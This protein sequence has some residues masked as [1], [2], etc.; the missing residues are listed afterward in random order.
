MGKN[1]KNMHLISEVAQYLH[2]SRSFILI[3]SYIENSSVLLCAVYIAHTNGS[4]IRQQISADTVSHQFSFWISEPCRNDPQIKK[5]S[6]VWTLS[7]LLQFSLLHETLYLSVMC[8]VCVK[9]PSFKLYRRF[10]CLEYITEQAVSECNGINNFQTEIDT[11]N[12]I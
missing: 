7:I 11:I 12:K 3:I 10:L 4:L 9:I 8:T 5:A 1:V 2:C 6:E